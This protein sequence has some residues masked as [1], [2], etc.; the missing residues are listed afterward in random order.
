[1]HTFSTKDNRYKFHFNS[2]L[3]GEIII[4]DKD[5]RKEIEIKKSI[6]DEFFNHIQEV[7][8]WAGK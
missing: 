8:K 5:S 4:F 1:M 3:S 7:L 2:D 6:L